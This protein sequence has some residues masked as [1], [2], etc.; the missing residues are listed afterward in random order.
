MQAFSWL[1]YG[2]AP[3]SH[4]FQGLTHDDAYWYF[5][6]T[7]RVWKVPLGSRSEADAVASPTVF[8]IGI[9]Q[10]MKH[11]GDIDY[12]KGHLYVPVEPAPV[13]LLQLDAKTL[14]PVK[15]FSINPVQ[16]EMPWVALRPSD[17]MAFSSEF[18]ATCIYMHNLNDGAVRS[19]PL[20][21]RGKP[22]AIDRVQ[23]GT[24]DP[25]GN[26]Y[27]SSDGEPGGVYGV[28]VETGNV[29]SHFEVPRRSKIFSFR[30]DEVEG[31]TYWDLG[32]RG[33]LHVSLLHSF[34]L[35]GIR[36]SLSI[37]GLVQVKS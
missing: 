10:S 14:S 1:S 27:L 32:D 35:P 13:K 28:D 36:D 34:H 37:R 18:N 31:L 33:Q 6:T 30:A 26:L 9:L 2:Y 19:I 22:F 24:F 3:W 4:H 16:K 12:Y 17:G 11:M 15:A 21:C 20:L 29:S 7:E 23:G 5:S 25:N 8:D